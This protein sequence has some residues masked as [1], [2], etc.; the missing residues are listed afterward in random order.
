MERSLSVLLPVRNVQSTLIDSVLELLEV[1]PELTSRFEL[2]IIDDGST[3]GSRVLL[4]D[5]AL[6][7]DHGPL[8][9]NRRR[10]RD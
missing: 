1:L 3:D 7:D 8:R 6:R 4:N 10:A 9:P 5:L 2:I